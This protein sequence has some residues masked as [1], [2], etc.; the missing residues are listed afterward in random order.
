M[1][2]FQDGDTEDGHSA[3]SPLAISPVQSDILNEEIHLD[4]A[5]DSM[6]EINK[7]DALVAILYD[8]DGCTDLRGAVQFRSKEFLAI[9]LFK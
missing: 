7:G 9:Q 6:S 4:Q 2:S 1:F 5:E 8:E 3:P